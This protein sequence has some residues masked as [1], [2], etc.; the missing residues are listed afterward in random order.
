M[1]ASESNTSESPATCPSRGLSV[2]P[3]RQAARTSHEGC[4][5]VV[6]LNLACRFVSDRPNELLVDDIKFIRAR[7]I[8]VFF[9]FM[10]SRYKPDSA[11]Q[12]R[13][14]ATR[15]AKHLFP[16]AARSTRISGTITDSTS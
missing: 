10:L 8:F 5:K 16:R 2:E 11:R 1:K 4:R 7:L 9:M 6:F 3:P 15:C 14:T 13:T 12:C